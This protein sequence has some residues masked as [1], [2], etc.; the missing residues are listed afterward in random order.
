MRLAD[1][2][3]VRHAVGVEAE[4][5]LPFAGLFSLFRD[6]GAEIDSLVPAQADA[7][8]SALS[9]G[10]PS[11]AVPFAIAA[12]TVSLLAAVAEREGRPLLV[13]IDDLQWVDPGSQHALLFA[14]RRLGPDAVVLLFAVRDG[15][16][17]LDLAGLPLLAVCGLARPDVERLLEGKDVVLAGPALD[18]VVAATR[19][20]PLGVI[21]LARGLSDR[22]RA[23][24]DLVDGSTAIGTAGD[25]DLLRTRPP[26]RP[27]RRDRIARRRTRPL[28]PATR[29]S[30]APSRPSGRASTPKSPAWSPRRVRHWSPST[31]T[32]HRRSWL[33]A[34][35]PPGLGSSSRHPWKDARRHGS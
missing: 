12:G 10:P 31:P 22:Q 28:R 32:S 33:S 21:E 24:L 2:F 3:A 6:A 29:S 17:E 5:D 11:P 27:R 16:P 26:A 15:H 8:R 30:C 35:P 18:H 19:G 4:S 25:A 9:L 13:V 34:R 1:G 7:L 14:A 20:N 23:G